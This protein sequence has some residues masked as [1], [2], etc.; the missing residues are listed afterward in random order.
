MLRLASRRISRALAAAGAGVMLAAVSGCGF[1]L[2]DTASTLSPALAQTY[3]ASTETRSE[4]IDSLRDVLRLHGVD[5]VGERDAS[6]VLTIEQDETGT[7]LL[8]VNARNIAREYE[9]YYA[10]TFSLRVAG[11]EPVTSE[12]ILLTRAYTYDETKVL[13]KAREEQILRRALAED[14]ARQVVRRIE[15]MQLAA[16]VTVAPQA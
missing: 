9:I 5:I 2:Q 14:L 13:A 16:P 3:I 7:R 11:H 4:F 12:P 6:A 15:A 8:S 10:V 1:Q